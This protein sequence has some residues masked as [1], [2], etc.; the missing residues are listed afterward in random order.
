MNVEPKH[1]P[2]VAR[3][4][5]SEA[6][7]GPLEVEGPLARQLQRFGLAPG[8]APDTETWARFLGRVNRMMAAD[9]QDREQLEAASA[10]QQREL[11][12][13]REEVAVAYAGELGQ[14]RLKVEAILEAVGDSLTA[15]DESGALLLRNHVA[16]RMLGVQRETTATEFFSR[17]EVDSVDFDLHERA[18]AGA[19]IADVDAQFCGAERS[20]PLSVTV[21][22]LRDAASGLRGYVIV[23]RDQ[24]ERRRTQEALAQALSEAERAAQ[25]KSDFLA[26]MSHEIRT[27]M[28]GVMGMMEL[29]IQSGLDE[30]QRQYAKT[31]T[32]SAEALLEIINDIL[33][34]AKLEAGKVR[35]ESI[36]FDLR[37]LLEE[38]A[39]LL[40]PRARSK[41]LELGSF[42]HR[43]VPPKVFGDPTRLRQILL[44]LAG[45][46]VKFT[47]RG[48]VL[49]RCL[50][51]GGDRLRIEVQDTGIGIPAS[52][53]GSLFDPFEQV[54]SSTTRRFGGTGLGLAITK[55]LVEAMRGDLGVDSTLGQGSTFYFD[56]ELPAD[57]SASVEKSLLGR[58]FLILDP[59]SV[60]GRVAAEQVA[61][62]GAQ[63]EI[64]QE[65][66]DAVRLLQEGLRGETFDACLFTVRD[67]V[68][69]GAFAA[70]VRGKPGLGE[71]VLVALAPPVRHA[72]AEA[73][74]RR[75]VDEVVLVPIRHNSLERVL[76]RVSGQ[77]ERRRTIQSPPSKDAVFTGLK[78]LVVEDN[79][80]NQMVA[81]KMLER[82][83]CEVEIAGHGQGAL[84]KIDGNAG[85]DVV[86]MDC[87]MPVMDG[88]EA[89]RHIR[90]RSDALSSIPVVALTANT[91]P[92]DIER[93]FDAGMDAY[94]SKPVTL[95]A[96]REQLDA[97][98]LAD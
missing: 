58:R 32:S 52:R 6:P 2:E 46:A 65:K 66:K 73:L 68:R 21:A 69:S 17:I 79:I 10:T 62:L 5:V 16:R 82:L 43:D 88:Y 56:V 87:Q 81:R 7:S 89:T 29:L 19:Y 37:S 50:P 93:C 75:W 31:V 45:N 53:I 55:Q 9:R 78:V 27:P 39:D 25:A 26:T 71:T 38:V 48:T 61:R 34:F 90:A 76:K 12:A 44:N 1:P 41:K 70:W 51:L 20:F 13:L 14:E 33:D 47:E 96:L 28:N 49:I 98:A 3:E 8:V 57:A 67:K 86:L 74:R 95:A 35:L 40:A 80:V 94:V 24:T 60:H 22:P 15:F 11:M 64:V 36:S 30:E 85:Y 18:R 77:T 92:G 97:V 54:D 72:E 42:I 4:Q 91:L 83:E 59:D 63:A 23:A 84:D